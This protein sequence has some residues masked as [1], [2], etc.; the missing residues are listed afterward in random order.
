MSNFLVVIT[1]TLKSKTL[2]G[3]VY[4]SKSDTFKKPI[5]TTASKLYVSKLFEVTILVVGSKVKLM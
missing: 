3:D 5:K 1:D 2:P 4:M